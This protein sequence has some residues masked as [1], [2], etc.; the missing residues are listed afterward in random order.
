MRTLSLCVVLALSLFHN[1][2]FSQNPINLVS[3]SQEE[4]ILN[5]TIDEYKLIEVLTPK[6]PAQI[7]TATDA[8]AITKKGAPDLPKLVRS[9]IIPDMDQM[10]FEVTSSKFIELSGIDIAPS[11]GQF[12]RNQDPDSIP[13]VY[14]PWYERDGFYPGKL[15]RLNEPYILRDFRGQALD[16][17]P[18]QYNPGTKTLRIYTELTI[19]AYSTGK[20][21]ENVLV[22][23]RLQDNVISEFQT[24]YNRQFINFG[25]NMRYT[26]LEEEGQ[27]LIICY[28]A[29]QSAMQPFVE[30]KNTIGIPT[31]MVALSSVGTTPA[32]IKSYISNYYNA[33][34]LAYVLL[35]GDAEQIPPYNIGLI[36]GY[37]DNAY[38]YL[39]G[40]DRYQEIFVGRFSAQNIAQV[41]TQVQRSLEYEQAFDL[42]NGW[43]HHGLGIARN[44]GAGMGHNGGEADYVHMDLIRGKLLNYTYDVVYREYDGNVP[45]LANTT[46]A[47]ISQ[48]INDGVGVIN[49]C[50][51][52]SVTGWSVAG[53]S[54]THVNALTNAGKLPFIWAVACVNGQFQGQTCFAETWLRATNSQNEP[55]GAVAVFMSTIN[56]PWHPPMDAQDEFNDIMTEL[57]TSN[58]KRSY[59]GISINGVY[60]M[61]D[62]NPDSYGYKTAETWTVFGDPTLK[63]RTDN[64]I[65]M[66][67]NHDPH[68]SF[69]SGD[70]EIACDAD[71]A[72]AVITRNGEIMSTASAIAGLINISTSGLSI[73]DEV[74]L[75][76]TAYN[77]IPYI[78]DLDVMTSGPY[79]NFIADPIAPATGETVVFS[80]ASGGG[81][82]TI[83]EWNF[84]EGA[85]PATAIG[86]GPHEVVYNTPGGKTISLTVDGLYFREKAN[87]VQVKD[88]FTLSVGVNG[89][90]SVS[91]DGIPYT[92]A[93]TLKEGST[94]SLLAIADVSTTFTGWSGDANSTS[95]PYNLL[96]NAD[97]SIIAGF[98]FLASATYSA[99]DISTDFSFQSLP[100]ASSC[101][102]TLSISIP[103]GAII[104]AVDVSYS[105][106]AL[107]YGY[108]SEQC[109]QLRCISTG[110]VAE[111]ALAWGSGNT[112]GT[113]NYNRTG[114]SIANNVTGGGTI[115]FQLHA[116]RTWG[117]TG[118]NTTYNKVNN[119][120]WTIKV[121]YLPP[122]V[123]PA[124]ETVEATD[125]LSTSARVGGNIISNGGALVSDKGV[126]W[127]LDPNPEISGSQFS[128]GNG[129][130]EFSGVLNSLAPKT[131]YYVKAYAVNSAG[132]AYGQQLEFTTALPTELYLENITLSQ[133][134]A[135]CF[136]ATQT[137]TLAGAGSVFL[138]EADAIAEIVAGQNI[139][140]LEGTSVNEGAYFLARI[141]TNNDYCANPETMVMTRNDESEVAGLHNEIIPESSNYKIFPNPS[142]GAF[143]LA[144]LTEVK[145]ELVPVIIYNLM[146]EQILQIS[147]TGN[148]HHHFD[149]S[150]W[151]RG[152]YLI[153]VMMGRET[154]F[155]KIIIR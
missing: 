56:Q 18:F 68:I 107:N 95:N 113:F 126:Y 35:V 146:G 1:L 39:A 145:P 34:N 21:G 83:W 52:G 105:M 71:D 125:I 86:P 61:L 13:F 115:Q 137:I 112:T 20:T 130:G 45:G 154:G 54:A 132:M 60:K 79:A 4:V 101:P 3:G 131:T 53:Y 44:E 122:A 10:E 120:T 114:L 102:G 143:T 33:N 7:L 138:V 100:G 8:H 46:A 28:D 87:Y 29:F 94:V 151:P 81:V 43:L 140:F 77:R 59:G 82:F 85:V 40:S 78:T 128:L 97:K 41:Q 48:R 69:G 148:G 16:I 47:L 124:V 49:Y 109:T 9:I 89:A 51:H 135:E 149:L 73:G 22:R 142:N 12:D 50:N 57:Y 155:E 32:A 30:W 42:S 37:S 116:G 127:S 17:Y 24:I 99:G 36:E 74:T 31:E 133:Y 103:T 152:V 153:R 118:C 134:Q 63:I 150:H 23:N 55:T 84:G 38:G 111:S 90:G 98:S 108:M 139:V 67:V 5:I 136:D 58:T 72:F 6:G 11:K 70:F 141:A 27:M 144:L 93:L 66:S 26:P 80:D 147:V 62:L 76:I 121:Y 104:T 19:R 110:G 92:G 88:W 65:A 14:G 2:I 91:V 106:T 119:N 129:N 117:G 123:V 15:A 64:A 75:A 96:M 25:E